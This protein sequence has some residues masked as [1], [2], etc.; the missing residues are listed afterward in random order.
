MDQRKVNILARELGPKLFGRKPVAVHHHMLMGL[1]VNPG[2]AGE[3]VERSIAL[4]MSKS[5]PD[6]AVFMTDSPED[7]TRKIKNAY[8]PEKQVHENPIIEYCKHV[9]F[10]KQPV[11]HIERSAKFGGPL[12]I[13]GFDQLCSLSEQ[14]KLHP[15]DLKAAVGAAVNDLLE[16]TRKYFSK[17]KP[18]KLLEQV[19]SFEVTR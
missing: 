3:G 8:C 4:K 15:M 19:R 5:R 16:P 2:A 12:D 9:V 10:P 17:G 1:Q 13:K 7:V 11:L 14:G 6:S 18:A